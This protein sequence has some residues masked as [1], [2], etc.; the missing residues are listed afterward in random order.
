MKQ[1]EIFFLP[2]SIDQ[3]DTKS[4]FL[5][6][7]MIHIPNN[8]ISKIKTEQLTSEEVIT[9]WGIIFRFPC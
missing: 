2:R 7:I 9:I 4:P 3:S 8:T 1:R 6:I 5:I